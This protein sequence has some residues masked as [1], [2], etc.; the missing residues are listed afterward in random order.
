MRQMSI[1][2][3][4]RLAAMLLA[5]GQPSLASER[6]GVVLLHGKQSAPEQH[7]PLAD[8]IAAAGYPVEHPEMCWS[9][10]RI[11]DRPYLECLREIDAAVDRLKAQ[12]ATAFVIAG[13]SL[14][15]NAALAY[16][17]RHR[18]AGV[19]ALA[20]G[21]A[22]EFIANRPQVAASLDRARRLVAQRQGDV[23][24]TF[25]DTN[26][27]VEIS[28]TATPNAYLSFLSPDGPA[29]MPKNAAKLMAPLLCVVGTGDP[30]QRGREYFFAKAPRYPLNRYV[31]VHATH[32]GT[33]EAARE[34]VVDWLKRIADAPRN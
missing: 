11:Y 24:T 25:A 23:T 14:G 17:A 18:V 5:F 16:G 6:I 15:A 32:F 31:T 2:R 8:A 4:L 22:V 34:A 30:I 33:S 13:H 7:G 27:N 12:G 9:G 19:I 3:L 29:V 28:V 1:R 10:R 20:P 21:H 26:G